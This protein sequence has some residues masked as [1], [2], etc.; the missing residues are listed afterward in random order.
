MFLGLFAWD[1]DW[2]VRKKTAR[3]STLAEITQA[4]ALKGH[5]AQR[6]GHGGTHH[7]VIFHQ[8]HIIGTEGCTENDAGDALE[9]VDPLLSLWSLPSHIKH[10][11]GGN[12]Y[13][14]G[15]LMTYMHLMFTPRK[16]ATLRPVSKMD[17]SEGQEMCPCPFLTSKVSVVPSGDHILT[18]S[19]SLWRKTWSQWCLWF[20]LW[21]VAHLAH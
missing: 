9:A 18:W 14:V 13:V 17:V 5:E 8:H 12:S 2:S 21:T 6:K 11:E 1:I 19:S 10:P 15:T 20:L 4:G 16:V 3:W 7:F